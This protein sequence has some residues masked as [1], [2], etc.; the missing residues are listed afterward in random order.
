[1]ETQPSDPHVRWSERPRLPELQA[2]RFGRMF[3]EL[4]PH[5]AN[6]ETLRR[7][8]D[9]NGPLEARDHLDSSLDEDNPRIPAGWPFFGQFI[10]HDI[11]HDRTPL[12]EREDV[13]NV[14][15]FR[16]PRLD[17]ECV[18]AAGPVGQ[19]YLY[20]IEDPD[21]LLIAHR[22][23]SFEDLP[24]NE[25]GL[26]LVGDPRND[27]HLFI[28]QLHLAFLRFHNRVVDGV[29]NQGVSPD[30][31]FER[32]RQMVRWHYQWIV[33]HEFLPLCVGEDT[34]TEILEAGPKLCCF[35]GKPSYSRRICACPK[36]SYQLNF[37]TARIVNARLRRVPLFPDLVGVRAVT[38]Q[39]QVDWSRLF[40][41][42][43]AAP[44]LAS[45]RIRPTLVP[46]LLRLPEELVGKP[47]H[48]EFKSLASRD[49]CRGRS[50]G[51]PSGEAIAQ[52]IGA[53]PFTRDGMEGDPVPGCNGTPLWLYILTEAEAEQNGERLGTV[54][55]RIVAEV[56]IELLRL[57]PTS[58][59]S[60]VGWR[61]ELGKADGSFGIT[62]LLGYADV[63]A[64]RLR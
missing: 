48:P 27:T 50:V 49:L 51:L 34:V 20:D 26:A 16:S 10:A 28:S 37:Q 13:P 1:L 6:A 21:K 14:R 39:R 29:R 8:G 41:F 31:A 47:D 46:Q 7:Y 15:N 56:L 11:T 12:Q 36:R 45:R 19:P 59:L 64:G 61:P 52:A 58:I 4:P 32:A 53:T 60:Q 9:V 42:P 57:D 62:D 23:F 55:G 5:C 3:P 30:Q 43:D 35:S 33:L 18:Y 24:R 22:D 17:L 54:G 25:Q 63:M 2:G 38:A 40:A 44:P